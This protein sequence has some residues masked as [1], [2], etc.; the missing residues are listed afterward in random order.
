MLKVFNLL[1]KVLLKQNKDF[2]K[3]LEDVISSGKGIEG[4]IDFINN[5]DNKKN[6]NL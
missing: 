3:S 1:K 5:G 2:V 4:F 6:W